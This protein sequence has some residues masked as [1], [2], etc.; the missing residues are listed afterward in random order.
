MV[1]DVLVRLRDEIGKFR[2][3]ASGLSTTMLL[4][5]QGIQR[6]WLRKLLNG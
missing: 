1:V 3:S 4:R 6:F 2:L 5:R